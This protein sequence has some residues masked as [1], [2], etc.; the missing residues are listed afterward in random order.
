[1]IKRRKPGLNI[2][3]GLFNARACLKPFTGAMILATTG[4]TTTVNA[5]ENQHTSK[6]L[7]SFDTSM[8]WGA[9][10]QSL[11]VERYNE[12]NP[13]EPGTYSV[14]V[15]LNNTPAGRHD[16]T[17]VP[18]ASAVQAKPAPSLELLEKIGV[19]T[20]TLQGSVD[21]GAATHDLLS[22]I[23]NATYRYDSADQR[24]DLSVPQAA[25]LNRPRGYVSPKRWNRGVNAAFVDYNVNAYQATSHGN[26]NNTA[27]ANINVGVNVGD[28][29]LRQRSTLNWNKKTGGNFQTFTRYAHRDIDTLRS[30]VTLGDSF[31]DGELFDTVATRGLRLATDDRM[32]PDSQRGYAPVIR[33]TASTNALITIRQNGFIIQETTVA[34]GAFTITDLNPT[35]G[36]V[37]LDVTVKEADGQEKHFTVPLSSVSRSLREGSSRYTATVGQARELPYGSKPLIV[38]GTYQR[39]LSNLI[40]S[41]TGFSAAEGYNTAI[42]GGVLNSQYGAFGTD[43]T[44]SQTELEGTTFAGQS[45]RVTYNKIL[46]STGTHLTVAAYRHSDTGYFGITEALNAQDQLKEFGDNQG[47][48][49]SIRH[50]RGRVQLNISQNLGSHSH[51]YL[52][53]SVQSYWNSSGTDKQYQAGFSQSLNWGSVGVSASSTQDMFGN[54]TTE[55][56]VNVSVPLGPSSSRNRP[57]LTASAT[58]RTDG[59]ENLQT[60]LSGS[61]GEDQALSYGITTS[62]NRPGNGDNTTNVSG[63]TQFHTSAANLSASLSK[64]TDFQQTSMGASG[65][66]VVHPAGITFGQPLGDS[67]AIVVAPDAAGAKLTNA[68]GVK[69]DRHGQAVVPYLN[70]YR[71][72]NLELDPKGIG[73]DV[74]LQNTSQEVVPRSGSIIMAKFNTV[75]GRALLINARQAD[76]KPLPFGAG[77]YDEK[78]QEVG[79]VG[80][81]GQIFARLAG[82]QGTLRISSNSKELSQCNMPYR[83]KPR[84]K[85]EAS[86]RLQTIKLTCKD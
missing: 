10:A 44:T 62:N 50:M 6:K 82:D 81:G 34:P 66:I 32:L 74:E 57:Y 26:Q 85:G 25:L 43:I 21:N 8:L 19:D 29:R 53:S 5:V 40:T 45:A 36:A 1:M 27:Y 77:V 79:A 83:L 65:S 52:N 23:P 54:D 64:G 51:L 67:I 61:R 2:S 72:N 63:N 11:N 48:V 80:Q 35:S 18:G 84:E 17:F 12:G 14:D 39:G 7:A 71:V 16:I 30:Q 70:P 76:G 56:M 24:L 55:Y 73:D 47:S 3:S 60:T 22:F 42:L 4:L 78:G 33:G 49:D 75:S 58:S 59:S 46:Q 41:Y 68:T 13:V 38:Q 69:L 31:T 20:E 86:S 37:N 15:S 28:W 9:G